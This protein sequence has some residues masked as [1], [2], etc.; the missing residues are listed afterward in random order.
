MLDAVRSAPKEVLVGPVSFNDDRHPLYPPEGEDPRPWEHGGVAPNGNWADILKRT[1]Q[2]LTA[3]EHSQ[4]HDG[5]RL[6]LHRLNKDLHEPDLRLAAF[7]SAVKQVDNMMKRDNADAFKFSKLLETDPAIEHA[8][9]YQA[10]SVQYSRPANSL[11]GAIARLS[12]DQMWRVITRVGIESSVWHVPHMQD[13]VNNQRIH[14]VVVAEVAAHLSGEI[15]CNEYV[16]GLV[17]GMGRLSIYRA[18][19]RHRRGPAPENE[20]VVQVCNQFYPVIGVLI[21]RV[22]DLE[23]AIVAAMGFHNAPNKAPEAGKKAAWMIHLAN[24]IAYTAAAEAEGLDSDGRV[25]LAQ[26][27]GVRFNAEEAFDVAHDALSEAEAFVAAQH[28]EAENQSS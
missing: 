25:T 6:F 18:A 12:Q 26:M 4:S 10:N 9:W 28:L 8:V 2:Q 22:W 21:G 1:L 27:K 3:L 24:I 23:P 17:H 5:N 13:W 14:A 19:V 11:R 7:P 16:A 20:F 15:R